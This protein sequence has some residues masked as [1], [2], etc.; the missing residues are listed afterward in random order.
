MTQRGSRRQPVRVPSGQGRD[1]RWRSFP[2]LAAFV[3][4]AL[5]ASFLDRPDTDFAVGVRIVLVIAAAGCLA[6]IVVAY[7]IAPRRHDSTVGK[8][9]ETAYE[10][11]LVYDE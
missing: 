5:I 10:D 11:E 6:H 7:V 4:G 1:W 2:V 3:F 9:K 8:P